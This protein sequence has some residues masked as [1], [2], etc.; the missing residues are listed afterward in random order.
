MELL[1]GKVIQ[2]KKQM[3]NYDVDNST[4][5]SYALEDILLGEP[6]QNNY[7]RMGALESAKDFLNEQQFKNIESKIDRVHEA[8]YDLEYAVHELIEE[9]K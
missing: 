6:N 8:E 5:A 4:D 7:D 3:Y 1:V 9:L 2:R